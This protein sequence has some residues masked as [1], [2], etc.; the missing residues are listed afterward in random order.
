MKTLAAYRNPAQMSHQIST[1]MIMSAWGFTIVIASLLFLYLGHLLDLWLGTEPHFMFG[2][3][4][5]AV[6]T[7]IYRLYQEARLRR[8]DF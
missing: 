6:A 3:F 5:L 7:S 4:F 2:L 1:I 8:K